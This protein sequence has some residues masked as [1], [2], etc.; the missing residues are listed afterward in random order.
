MSSK[1][2]IL[3]I[4]N[5]KA[6]KIKAIVDAFVERGHDVHMLAIPPIDGQ[7]DGVTWH[8]AAGASSARPGESRSHDCCRCAA[9]RGGCSRTSCMRTTRGDPAGTA[10]P[11][12]CTRS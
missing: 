7:W 5:G 11:S 12:D 3:H 9:W 10:P 4:G 1:L 2:R 6:F 8:R